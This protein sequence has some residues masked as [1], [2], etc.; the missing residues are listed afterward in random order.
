M[1]KLWGTAKSRLPHV[2]LCTCAGA[3]DESAEPVSEAEMQS[4]STA[5]GAVVLQLDILSKRSS[6]QDFI[7]V[8]FIHTYLNIVPRICS[9]LSPL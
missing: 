7:D 5:T 6:R 2:V 1:T 8:R 9:P 3:A 4:L